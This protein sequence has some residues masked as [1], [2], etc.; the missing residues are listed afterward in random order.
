MIMII[1]I[2][3][4]QKTLRVGFITGKKL[5]RL[6]CKLIERHLYLLESVY[7]HDKY[8][9]DRVYRYVFMFA[10][11]LAVIEFRFTHK[12]VLVLVKRM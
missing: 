11:Y 1:L 6:K 5:Y 2:E 4:G 7:D 12:D 3:G 10:L 8:K 9:H